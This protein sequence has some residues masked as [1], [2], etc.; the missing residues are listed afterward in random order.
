MI[1]KQG[2]TE[3]Y[4]HVLSSGKLLEWHMSNMII[5]LTNSKEVND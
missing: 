5:L 1:V 3:G 4:Y 2:Y